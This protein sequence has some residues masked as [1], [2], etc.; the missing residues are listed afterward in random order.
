MKKKLNAMRKIRLITLF[1][2]EL[3]QVLIPIQLHGLLIYPFLVQAEISLQFLHPNR[4]AKYLYLF[5][6]S[7][8]F[9]QTPTHS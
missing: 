2:G 7:N 6:K 3:P 8:N 5:E 1:D 9:I 4:S